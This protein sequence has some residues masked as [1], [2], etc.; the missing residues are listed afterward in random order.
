M[1]KFARP[2]P[3]RGALNAAYLEADMEEEEEYAEDFGM[4]A[5]ERARQ[6]LSRPRRVDEAAEVCII[7]L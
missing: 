2:A 4:T 7:A 5:T 3:A 6:A 1:R